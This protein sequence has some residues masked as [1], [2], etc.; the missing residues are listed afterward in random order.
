MMG[1]FNDDYDAYT[2]RVTFIFDCWCSKK[3]NTVIQLET[4]TP[5]KMWVKP[6]SSFV[7]VDKLDF[8]C[9]L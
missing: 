3:K 2:Q 9:F 7:L 5:K 6:S 4:R 1:P 8:Q